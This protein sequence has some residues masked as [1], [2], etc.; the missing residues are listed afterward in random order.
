MKKVKIISILMAASMLSAALAGCGG[1]DN[2]ASEGNSGT[3]DGKVTIHYS[4]YAVGTHLSAPFETAFL[5]RFKEKY[6][7]K[8]EVVVE[9]LPSDP[10]YTDK[11]KTLA[12][13]NELPDMVDGKNGL[14][15]LAIKNGQAVELTEFLN[16]DPNFRDEVIGEEA[17]AA[18]TDSDGKIYSI[19]GSVQAVGYFYNQDLFEKAGVQPAE[20]WDEFWDNCDKLLDSGIVPMALMTGENSW[21]TNL[22]LATM[23]GSKSE[24]GNTL[25]N[26]KYPETYQTPEMIE[27]LEEMQTALQKYTTADAL[28]AAYANAANNFLQEQAAM[29]FNGSWMIADFSNE[30]KA[31]AGLADHIGFAMYPENGLIKTYAEG[32]VICAKTPETQEAAFTFL[33]EYWSTESQEDRMEKDGSIPVSSEITISDEF[34]A[35]NPLFAANVDAVQKAETTVQTCDVLAYASVVDAFGQYYPEL[36]AGSLDAAGMAEKLDEAAAK[37]E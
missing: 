5:E 9:E 17:L 27:S 14:R 37:A 36:A 2:S 25:M 12:A 21:T 18:Q 32:S 16:S 7:D 34:K 1:N 28:G 35:S 15:D 30:E 13:T 29:I 22:L 33:K 10:V 8:I 19:F 26:T 24:T 11:M 3:T 23:V 6:G 4:T 31:V 20:T